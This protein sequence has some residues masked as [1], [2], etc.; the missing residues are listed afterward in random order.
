MCDCATLPLAA[1]EIKLAHELNQNY[2]IGRFALDFSDKA[3]G[4]P[5]VVDAAFLAALRASVTEVAS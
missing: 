4:A 5:I 2:L 1:V 3:P